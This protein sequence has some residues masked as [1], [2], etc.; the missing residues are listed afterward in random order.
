[1]KGNRFDREG[2]ETDD[3]KILDAAV[4]ELTERCTKLSLQHPIEGKV[5]LEVLKLLI[6]AQLKLT[7]MWRRHS[8][9]TNGGM[10]RQEKLLTCIWSSAITYGI[11]SAHQ[12]TSQKRI[13]SDGSALP[14]D[15]RKGIMSS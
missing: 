15:K 13:L 9:V 12:S 5:V 8:S 14:R 4:K 11:T 2:A 10:I 3:V 1:M 7:R 6:D